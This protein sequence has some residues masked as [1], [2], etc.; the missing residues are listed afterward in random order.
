MSPRPTANTPSSRANSVPLRGRNAQGL[1]KGDKA[2]LFI[3][4]EALSLLNGA[5]AD[6]D[7]AI[8]SR[9]VN[10]SFEGSF[11]HLFLEG[12]S[13][14][15]SLSQT[16]DGSAQTFEP[17]QSAR[18]GFRAERAVVLPGWSVGP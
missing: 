8:E 13:K 10:E 1:R 17:G 12:D 4:P 9:I 18:V 5:G 3:R 16:N 15:I 6:A 14:D 11:L 7:N 2:I